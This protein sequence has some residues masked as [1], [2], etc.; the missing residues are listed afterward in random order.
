MNYDKTKYKV[1]TWKSPVMLHWVINPGCAVGDLIGLRQ[2]KVMLIERN[3]SNPLPER[4]FIPCPHCQ[5][6]HSGLKW[7]KQ[8][9]T[10]YKNWFGLY[11][12]NCEKIIPCMTNL[13]SY[14]ILG[15]T[16]PIWIWFKDKWKAKWIE[17]QKAKFSKPLNLTYTEVKFQWLRAGVF[18]GLLMYVL[19]TILTPLIEGKGITQRALLIGIPASTIGGLVYVFIMRT[20]YKTFY[21]KKKLTTQ[22]E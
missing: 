4:T 20:Y 8:N 19:N 6:L 9:K 13:I 12:D 15:L 7:S 3:S 2:P 10:V 1:W 17:E 14:V 21:R 16:F 18:F 5:T 22:P 11:C